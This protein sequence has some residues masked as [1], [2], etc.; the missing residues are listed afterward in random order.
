MQPGSILQDFMK[1]MMCGSM[2][3]LFC[4]F[5]SFMYVSAEAQSKEEFELVKKDGTISVYERWIII[6]NTDP[7]IEAREVKGEFYF[8]NTIYAGL[9][10]IQDEEKIMQ[11]QD[12]VSEF[13]VYKQRD[14]TTWLEYSYHDIPWPVSDQDHLLV[15]TLSSPSPDVITLAFRSKV[16]DVIAP[17]RKGVTRMELSG[18][19][20][21][22]QIAPGKVK[23]TYIISSKPIGIPKFL[24]DPI[25]RSNIMT[26][27]KEYIALLEGKK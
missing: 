10:L 2:R 6:P 16:D 19:W 11:W 7:P 12:H 1:V 3:T 27:I 4:L 20:K 5:V 8:R 24:T 15:Y 14:T 13:K 18:S 26:T 17:V 21:L 25:I 23:A 22:E 9:H